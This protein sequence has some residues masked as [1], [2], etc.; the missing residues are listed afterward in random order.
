MYAKPLSK[1]LPRIRPSCVRQALPITRRSPR[2]P[3]AKFQT[4][5]FLRGISRTNFRRWSGRRWKFPVGGDNVYVKIPVTNTRRH[6]CYELVRKLTKNGAKV[7]VTALMALEQVRDVV[8]LSWT[9]KSRV[10]CRY[11]RTH[12]GHRARSGSADGRRRGAAENQAK[13]RAD[14]GQPA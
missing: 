4:V 8:V 10:T 7:N 11:S 13:S 2:K 1:G 12:C 6:P 5:P 3:F 9:R 14:L